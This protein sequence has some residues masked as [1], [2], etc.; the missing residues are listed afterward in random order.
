MAGTIVQELGRR[1]WALVRAQHGVVA[2][3][4]LLA[5]GL[6]RAAIQH[7]IDTARLHALWPGVYAVGR[8]QVGRKGRWMAA[9]LACGER[10]GLCFTSGAAL[11][12]FSEEE[13]SGVHVVV[14]SATCRRRQGILLHRR[15]SLPQLTTHVGIP[16]TTPIDTLIDLAGVWP[17]GRVEA[18][19]READ[20]LDLVDLRELRDAAD[21]PHRRG[22]R[23]MREILDRRQLSLTDSELERRFLPIAGRAGLP[24]PLTQHYVD[25]YRV[26]FFWPDLNLVV[27]T[28][29]LRY[30]RTPL[31]Q[32]RDRRRDQAHAAAGRTALRFTHAQ[33]AY[34]PDDVESVLRAVI[35]RLRNS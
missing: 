10:A 32:A 24:V 1:V 19:I 30:H 11:W 17:P 23:A 27:E 7:R 20:K 29:G 8:P 15:T 13:S 5:L 28:D 25:G 26:D 16:V 35:R 6:T 2:R 22:A 34:D 14:P 4:Q 18:A 9:V 3:R 21:E 31:Q 12:G 33:V